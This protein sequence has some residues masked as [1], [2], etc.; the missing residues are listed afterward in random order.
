MIA[1]G[2]DVFTVIGVGL[3]PAMLLAVAFALAAILSARLL[4]SEIR[5]RKVTVPCMRAGLP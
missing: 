2:L 1:V 4:Q 3:I 5:A